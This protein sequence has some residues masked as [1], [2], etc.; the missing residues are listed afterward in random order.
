MKQLRNL[1][2]RPQLVIDGPALRTVHDV[3]TQSDV[4]MPGPFGRERV[5][6][7]LPS[8]KNRGAVQLAA[9]QVL[10]DAARCYLA[11]PD[12][13]LVGVDA[14]WVHRMVSATVTRD[15]RRL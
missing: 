10:H 7:A 5:V 3:V 14:V 6:E 13:N 11:D 12:G 2:A 15:T 1:S 4:G 9:A 8:N